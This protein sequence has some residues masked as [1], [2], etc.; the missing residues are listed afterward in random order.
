MWIVRF[1]TGVYARSRIAQSI[2]CA[3]SIGPGLRAAGMAAEGVGSGVE[4]AVALAEDGASIDEDDED[5]DE[6]DEEEEEEEEDADMA[7]REEDGEE[8]V[9]WA[10]VAEYRRAHRPSWER[11]RLSGLGSEIPDAIS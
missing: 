5:D 6:D 9:L 4:P 10:A 3:A 2:R 8:D 7:V 11:S 1:D